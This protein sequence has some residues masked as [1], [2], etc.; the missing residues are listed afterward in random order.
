MD[1]REVRK[2]AKIQSPVPSKREAAVPIANVPSPRLVLAVG[3]DIIQLRPPHPPA[4]YKSI[5]KF[6]HGFLTTKFWFNRCVVQRPRHAGAIA[7]AQPSAGR[8][9]RTQFALDV[10]GGRIPRDRVKADQKLHDRTRRNADEIEIVLHRGRPE[11]RHYLRCRQPATIRLAGI[12][13]RA[14]P[15]CRG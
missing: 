10:D 3:A 2:R 1:V 4:R 9:E 5:F 13:R 12:F 8:I 7:D 14:I 6:R 15:A 11:R